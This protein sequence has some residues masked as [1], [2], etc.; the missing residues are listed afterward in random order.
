MIRMFLSAWEPVTPRGVAAFARADVR[1]LWLVQSFVACLVAVTIAW[2]LHR[3]VFPTISA[4]IEK[5]PPTGVIRDARLDWNAPS[6]LLLAEGRFLAMSVDLSHDG[7]ARAPAH[8]QV[9]FGHEGFI[10]CSLL[11]CAEFWYP[12]G[13]WIAFNRTEVLPKWGA[14]EQPA[15]ALI[16]FAVVGGFM[17]AWQVLAALYA[18]PVWL[19]GYYGNRRL[20]LTGSWKLAGA[21]LMPGA[22]MMSVAIVLYERGA[23]DLLPMAFVLAGHLLLGWIYLAISPWFVPPV[24]AGAAA[25]NPFL[26]KP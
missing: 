9:E 6:P 25:K 18:L 17:M 15:L 24:V 13:W 8:F 5:L 4:A 19:I 20:S 22:L 26:K 7:G 12:H 3:G 14:W 1:R 21:A 2:W 11:G 16:A 23:L 10:I